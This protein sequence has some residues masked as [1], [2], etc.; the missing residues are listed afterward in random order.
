VRVKGVALLTVSIGLMVI[1]SIGA[2]SATATGRRGSGPKVI[3]DGHLRVGRR[4]T[5]R[6]SGFPGKGVVVVHFLPT[7]ICEDGCGSRGYRVGSTDA[8]GAG[9]FK[10]RVPGT[11]FNVHERPTYFRDHERVNLG[12]S[13]EGAGESFAHADAHPDPEIVRVHDGGK[14]ARGGTRSGATARSVALSGPAPREPLLVP[15]GFEL[16]A[17]DGYTLHAVARA[18]FVG[19]EGSLQLTLSAKGREVTY[20]APATVTETSIEA[21][22]GALGEIA[23]EFQRS[24]KAVSASCQR[25]EVRFDSGSWVGT[26]QFHGEEGYAAVEATS[27]RPNLKRVAGESCGPLFGSAESGPRRGAELFIRNPG[28]GPQLSVYKHRP[29]A[30]ALIVARLREYIPGTSSGHNTGIEIERTVGTWMPGSDFTY[31]RRR[32]RTATVTPPA[33]FAGTA[34]FDHGLKAGMRWSGDLT[35]DMPGRADVPL[36]G[37]LLRAYLEP[38]E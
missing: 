26:I 37:R 7:A 25:G 38:S 4:E 1:A 9:T 2:G 15:A 3:T 6:V 29:E 31:D 14:S 21:D 24:N 12:V 18:P 35:V 20:E 30:A 16:P 17:G 28:L 19:S 13:W 27:A 23:V 22:L 5:I 10:V 32:L 33:P 36:T 11:F 8:A 34:H